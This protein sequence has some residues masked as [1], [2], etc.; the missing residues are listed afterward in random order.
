MFQTSYGYCH[1]DIFAYTTTLEKEAR[2]QT[3]Q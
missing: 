1:L 2:I 3:S